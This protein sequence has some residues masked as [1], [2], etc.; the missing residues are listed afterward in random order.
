MLHQPEDGSD[1]WLI[2]LIDTPGGRGSWDTYLS[3]VVWLQAAWLPARAAKKGYPPVRPHCVCVFAVCSPVWWGG[4]CVCGCV[5]S[6]LCAALWLACVVL[7][8][9]V[10]TGWLAAGMWALQAMSTSATKSVE[11]CQRARVPCC[12]WTPRKVGPLTSLPCGVRC[13]SCGPL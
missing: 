4:L 11:H 1:P 13:W 10:L 12:W 3:F 7:R 5:C 8:L 2:N 9:A 6:K